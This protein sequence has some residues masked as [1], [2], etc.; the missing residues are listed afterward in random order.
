LSDSQL[1]TMQLKL[2]KGT[3]PDE[4]AKDVGCSRDTVQRWKRKWI[5]EGKLPPEA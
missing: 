4:V 5:E 2:A 3:G 1:T